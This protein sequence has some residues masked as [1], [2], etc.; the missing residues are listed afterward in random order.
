M[1]ILLYINQTTNLFM[2]NIFKIFLG[3]FIFTLFIFSHKIFAAESTVKPSLSP[4]IMLADVNIR[5][6]NIISQNEN[7]F[8]ISFSVSNGKGIQSGVKY[9]VKLVSY[10]TKGQIIVDEKIYPESLTLYENISIQKELTYIAPQT[11]SGKYSLYL[12]SRNEGGFPFSTAFVKEINFI[13]NQKGLEILPESCS[14]YV[15]GEK[16]SPAYKLNQI[17]DIDSTETLSLTCSAVNNSKNEIISIPSVNINKGN[18]YGK[19]IISNNS[20]IKS[21]VFKT[22]E[23]KSFSVA[24]PQISEAGMYYLTIRLQNGEIVSNQINFSYIVR[25][26]IANITNLFL[27]KDYYNKGETAN[28]SFMWNSIT[29]KLLR[30]KNNED[31]SVFL[32]ASIFDKNGNECSELINK[33]LVQ[34]F[35]KPKTELP[36]LITRNCLNPGIIIS[37]KDKSG[38]T[39]DEKNFKVKTISSGHNK[40]NSIYLLVLIFVIILLGL[41]FYKKKKNNRIGGNTLNNIPVGIIFPFL[42]LI[43]FILIPSN[44]VSAATFYVATGTCGGINFDYGVDESMYWRG[45]T[46]VASGSAVATGSCSLGTYYPLDNYDIPDFG[47][48]ASFDTTA[49]Y[50]FPETSYT[51]TLFTTS[52]NQPPTISGTASFILPAT[53]PYKITFL[54]MGKNNGSIVAYG[55]SP[56]IDLDVR[57][58]AMSVWSLYTH[59]LP[60]GGSATIN[61][62]KEIVVD[63]TNPSTLVS[64]TPSVLNGFDSTVTSGAYVTPALSSTTTYTITCLDN[65]GY[66]ATGS[67]EILVTPPPPT[68]DL[69]V[70]TVDGPITKNVGDDVFVSWT[71]LNTENMICTCRCQDPFGNEID[72]G[73]TPPYGNPKSCGSGPYTLRPITIVG[74]LRPTVFKVS[75]NP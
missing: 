48:K 66:S 13:D 2:K 20:S 65:Y 39:I 14:L 6:V 22:E 58:T 52:L 42:F 19:L 26:N 53:G 10:T 44:K 12:T 18:V 23:K 27:D 55:N 33:P 60:N 54:G 28:L 38:K 74:V 51:K 9:G 1:L 34:D 46:L 71:S 5:D 70:D 57:T 37:L 75:C 49:T 17:V 67:I 7:I 47:L 45:Q 59:P 32:T 63:L 72:C 64:C 3:V 24:V 11:L 43:S 25:G 8:K 30:D 16:G 69:K 62:G 68:V 41:Y 56:K 29:G 36:I 61:W 40:I 15:V 73:S 35:T 50:E 4:V 21:V 31:F